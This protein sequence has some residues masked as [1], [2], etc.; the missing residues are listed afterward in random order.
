MYKVC[1]LSSLGFDKAKTKINR[2][3]K[4]ARGIL[5]NEGRLYNK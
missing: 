3:I 2:I 5:I 4:F 1:L